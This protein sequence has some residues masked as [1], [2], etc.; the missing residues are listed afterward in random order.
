M[1]NDERVELG[2]RLVGIVVGL[3]VGMNDGNAVG[4]QVG[5]ALELLAGTIVGLGLLG[6]L[7]GT[8]LREEVDIIVGIKLGVMVGD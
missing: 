2:G 8:S 7:V 4:G 5:I 1:G 6:V 3:I